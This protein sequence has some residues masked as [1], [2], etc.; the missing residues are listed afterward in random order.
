MK[1]KTKYN[2][3]KKSGISVF[4]YYSAIETGQ[5][6]VKKHVVYDTNCLFHITSFKKEDFI[7]YITGVDMVKCQVSLLCLLG[8]SLLL[9]PNM[10]DK[11][12]V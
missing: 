2:K 5:S 12:F 1:V 6:K 7:S 8:F 4:E 3:T 11:I 10:L 9:F